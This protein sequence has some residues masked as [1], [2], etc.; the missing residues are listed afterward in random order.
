M[1]GV[2]A[3]HSLPQP[4][5]PAASAAWA[6]PCTNEEHHEPPADQ[7]LVAA[8][9]EPVPTPLMLRRSTPR[10]DPA[11]GARP[12][13]RAVRQY[14]LNPL[15]QEL[16]GFQQGLEGARVVVDAL[17]GQVRI[18]VLGKDDP[19]GPEEGGEGFWGVEEEGEE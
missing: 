13:R 10:Y 12:V 5:T 8:R 6:A 16:L 18:R 7:A 2:T 3:Y 15:A 17:D 1:A 11:Y 19:A 9:R 4:A 14:V